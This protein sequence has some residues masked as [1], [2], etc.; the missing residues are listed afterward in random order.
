MDASSRRGCSR[1]GRDMLRLWLRLLPRARFRVRA[2]RVATM[3]D[4]HPPAFKHVC[5]RLLTPKR[6]APACGR[7][8]PAN[9]V[10]LT[11]AALTSTQ[12]FHEPRRPPHRIDAAP[13]TPRRSSRISPSGGVLLSESPRLSIHA[14][15]TRPPP[16]SPTPQPR[17][18]R[19]PRTLHP[20]PQPACGAAA[21]H[22][23]KHLQQRQHL[24]RCNPTPPPHIA[25]P[26][27][28]PSLAQ[29]WMVVSKKVAHLPSTRVR[30]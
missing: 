9:Q 23:H 4:T 3:H 14:T 22:H 16:P 5:V 15:P 27:G 30:C 2:A 25:T 18:P 8:L 20:P 29:P 10:L 1:F 11:K 17:T 24:L 7:P 12:A 28:A 6:T 26:R 19:S 13:P 21:F